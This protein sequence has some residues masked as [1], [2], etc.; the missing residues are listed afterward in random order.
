M[1]IIEWH[2][3]ATITEKILTSKE[4]LKIAWGF[5]VIFHHLKEKQGKTLWKERT[6]S[7]TF[8]KMN[9]DQ[10]FLWITMSPLTNQP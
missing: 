1:A 5:S 3:L 4:F 10:L 6:L 8:L 9:R 2:H 7:S